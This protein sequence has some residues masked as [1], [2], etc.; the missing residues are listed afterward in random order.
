MF[1]TFK[2]FHL[3]SKVFFS[4]SLEF[5]PF[6]V[7]LSII[8]STFTHTVFI[9]LYFWICFLLLIWNSFSQIYWHV[10]YI[11]ECGLSWWMSDDNSKRM[12]GLL[13]DI[14][15]RCP[16]ILLGWDLFHSALLL[17]ILC[18]L[19]LV[20]QLWLSCED[21]VK[22][23]KDFFYSSLWFCHFLSM[24][25]YFDAS[26]LATHILRIIFLW[27]KIVLL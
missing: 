27:W 14:V 25:T 12:Y 11:A 5:S 19:V 9:Q 23:N 3:T 26:S 18:L 8:C 24:G 21:D 7:Y 10:Y 16:M 6:S 22:C 1:P 17:L 4:N 15:Y 13:L 2:I 20:I